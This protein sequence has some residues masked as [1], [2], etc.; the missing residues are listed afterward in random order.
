M[1]ES[2]MTGHLTCKGGPASALV[3]NATFATLQSLGSGTPLQTGVVVLVVVVVVLVAVI[4]VDVTVVGQVSQRIGH[5]FETRAPIKGSEQD[6]NFNDMQSSLS[7][8]PSQT[9]VL[10]VVVE[11]VVVVVA[12]VVVAVV[13]VVEVVG[14]QESHSTG[15]RA[16]NCSPVTGCS[17]RDASST[18]HN[19]ISGTP[20]QTGVV[21]VVAVVAVTVVVVVDVVVVVT[22]VAVTVV[23]VAVVMVDVIVV[24]GGGKTQANTKQ[25][26]GERQTQRRKQTSARCCGTAGE[27]CYHPTRIGILP[28][29]HKAQREWRRVNAYH[30]DGCCCCQSDGCSRTSAGPTKQRT[31]DTQLFTENE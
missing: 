22:V 17:Q 12:V 11:V 9:G 8:L 3:H 20:L 31:P 29:N 16:R 23:A 30:A 4:V 6:E 14:M 25:S 21:V 10:V 2:H 13:V 15:Q 28:R 19:A 27:L 26:M 24:C 18:R 7:G 5:V 1:H